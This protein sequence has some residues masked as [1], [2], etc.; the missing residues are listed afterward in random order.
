MPD[1]LP[2][3]AI[4]HSPGHV[5]DL[6]ATACALGGAARDELDGVDLLPV[7]RGE[8]QTPA[9]SEPLCWEHFGHAAIR[10]GNWKLVRAGQQ[11]PW[12]LYDITTDRVEA[13]DRAGEFPEV[14]QSLQAAWQQWADRCGV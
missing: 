2:A 8:Q 5:I 6:V 12:E 1:G 13:R 10:A 3:G 4:R 11:Q 14:V 7:A 9:R